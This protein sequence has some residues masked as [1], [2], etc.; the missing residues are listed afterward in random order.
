MKILIVS[1]YFCPQITPRAFRTTELVKELC[2]RGEE[3]VLY[4]PFS[5]YSYAAFL[6][7]YHLKIRYFGNKS[8]EIKQP[9]GS[10]VFSRGLRF[11]LR[12]FIHYTEYPFIKCYRDIPRTLGKISDNFDALISIAAP[13]AVHWGCSIALKRNPKL[14]NLWIADCGDP[15]MGDSVHKHP[16]YFKYLERK[17]CEMVDFITV[18]IGEAKAAYYKEFQNKIKIIPQGFDFTPFLGIEKNYKKN[19]IPTFAYA[20]TLYRGYRDLDSLVD[21]LVTKDNYLF[22]LYVHNSTLVNSYKRKLGNRIEIRPLIPREQLIKELAKMDFLINIENV[23]TTQLPSKLIDYGL[24]KRPI[25]S[26]GKNINKTSVDEFL[27]FDFHRKLK[28]SDFSQYDIRNVV[29]SFL[30]LATYANHDR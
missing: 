12:L 2:R 30:S 24:A 13:H 6:S 25:L 3:V 16:F 7:K 4:I 17:F 9:K 22:I 23:G 21:Y 20:G 19:M 15:F 18:P 1:A 11:L 8:L 5:K 14:A 26:V 27:E 10:D 29:D 28:I